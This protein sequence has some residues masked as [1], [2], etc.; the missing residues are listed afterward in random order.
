MQWLYH[1]IGQV[2]IFLICAQTLIHFRPRESYEKYLKLL[3]SVMLLIQLFQPL[4]TVLG[5]DEI[6][7]TNVQAAE[8]AEEIRTV[9]EQ[10]AVQA[11]QTEDE[12]QAVTDTA[13]EVTEE[14]EP[15]DTSD[16]VKIRVEIPEIEEAEIKIR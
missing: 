8:F 14:T 15:P 4:L 2:G 10:A 7:A 6:A 5:G 3:L 16:P 11:E 9:L 13:A 1:V 12:I